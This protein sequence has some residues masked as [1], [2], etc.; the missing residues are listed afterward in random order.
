MEIVQVVWNIQR[1][2]RRFSFFRSI[3]LP[4]RSTRKVNLKNVTDLLVINSSSEL[5]PFTNYKELPDN[6]V[7]RVIE[8]RGSI[9]NPKTGVIWSHRKLLDESTVWSS[10]QLFRYEP[11]PILPKSISEPITLLPDN[12]Y[13]HFLIEDLPRYLEVLDYVSNAKTLISRESKKYIF[14]VLKILS[15]TPRIENVPV[16][17]ETLY[18]SEKNKGGIF[19]TSDLEK[20]RSFGYNSIENHKKETRRIFVLRTDNLKD[21]KG[22]SRGLIHQEEI[23]FEL[24]RTG[25]EILDCAKLGLAEQIEVFSSATVIAGFHG[26]G[27]ANQVWLPE[28]SKVIEFVGSRR[29][30]HFSHLAS[31][32]KHSYYEI[33]LK[34]SWR[35]KLQD[36]TKI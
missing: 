20:L 27:L 6:R 16:K 25:F 26:A 2:L 28:G 14:D 15:V 22:I 10:D 9:T 36:S 29:T 34:S 31:V 13:F 33:E 23:I 5:V 32:C 21:S 8:I 24:S 35:K 18:F 17:S 1:I 19:T 12:G 7:R 30:A 4:I 3:N 11:I